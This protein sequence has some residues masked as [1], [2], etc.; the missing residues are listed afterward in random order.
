MIEF[1]FPHAFALLVLPLLVRFFVPAFKGLHGDALKVPFLKDIQNIHLK[2]G[3]LWNFSVDDEFKFS[4]PFIVLY[5]IFALMVT[6]LARPQFVG[7]PIRIKS[8][9]RDILM[10]MD[11]SGSM[12]EQDFVLGR[13]RVSRLDAVKAVATSFI[14]TRLEDRIGL[15]LFGSRAYLQAPITFDKEAVKKIITDMDAQMAGNT[16]AIGDALGLALKT[17]KDAE[18]RDKKVVIL[19]TDG[20]SNDGSINMPQAI[21]LAKQE[22]I[23]IYTIGVGPV[24][25]YFDD[26]FGAL[27]GSGID[28]GS[29]NAIAEETK[30]RYFRATDTNALGKVYD[31]IN[32]LEPV[33]GEHNE[34]RET[35]ELFYIPLL[36]AFLLAGMMVFI[37]RKRGA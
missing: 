24:V 28:E 19:L 21:E 16:T 27:S 13:Q 14:D 4:K 6:A 12:L 17:L 29:L 10:V 9:G 25:S 34:I 20:E 22:G 7:E 26:F 36:L 35:K 11:L 5:V 23:K 18:D 37:R 32:K 30:A 2:A 3:G 8:M 1:L 31:E 33:I 15:V